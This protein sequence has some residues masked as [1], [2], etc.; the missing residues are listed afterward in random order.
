MSA[1]A[2]PGRG[3]IPLGVPARAR[4]ARCAPR[5]HIPPS[6]A[7]P[8]GPAGAESPPGRHRPHVPAWKVTPARLGGDCSEPWSAT[9]PGFSGCHDHLQVTPAPHPRALPGAAR[10]GGKGDAISGSP[11]SSRISCP[12]P[13]EPEGYGTAA[14]PVPTMSAGAADTLAARGHL[15]GAT[16]AVAALRRGAVVGQGVRPRAAAW[17][18]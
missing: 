11:P 16:A 7:R 1:A 18:L 6:P 13:K 5:G 8:W 4:E 10:P 15:C 17:G 3:A 12:E 9:M 2:A 14:G